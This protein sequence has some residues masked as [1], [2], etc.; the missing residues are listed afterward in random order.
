[1]K[2]ESSKFYPLNIYRDWIMREGQAGKNVKL[3]WV[4]QKPTVYAPSYFDWANT[5]KR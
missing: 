2:D 1:M 5:V 4:S 3:A